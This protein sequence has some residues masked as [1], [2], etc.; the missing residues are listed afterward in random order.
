MWPYSRLIAADFIVSPLLA[1]TNEVPY[2]NKN[3]RPSCLR[4]DNS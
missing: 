2:K 3:K 4:Q 1:A